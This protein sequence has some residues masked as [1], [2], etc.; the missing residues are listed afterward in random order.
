MNIKLAENSSIKI[1]NHGGNE[2]IEV[3]EDGTLDG[4]TRLY[5]HK[6]NY[7]MP[8]GDVYFITTSS[9]PLVTDAD[10]FNAYKSNSCLIAR[11]VRNNDREMIID[12]I[13]D[14]QYDTIYSLSSRGAVT[15]NNLGGFNGDTVTPL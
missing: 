10:R 6:L 9:T 12:F 15:E 2:I 13:T 1:L 5:Q 7:T 11:I 14:N 8:N 4:A 3:H